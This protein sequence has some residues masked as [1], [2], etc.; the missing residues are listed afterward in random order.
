MGRPFDTVQSPRDDLSETSS[1]SGDEEG[2]VIEGEEEP[3]W[4]DPSPGGVLSR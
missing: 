3:G 2:W 1:S 4:E